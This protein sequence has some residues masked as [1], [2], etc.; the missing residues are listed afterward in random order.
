M[1]FGQSIKKSSERSNSRTVL[2][3]D[4]NFRE[5]LSGLYGEARNLIESTSEFICAVKLNMHLV[6]PLSFSDLESLN[7]IITER[8]L[9][10]IADLKVN[11]IDNTNL[12]ASRYLWKAGFSAV[13]VNPFVGYEGG[14]DLLIREAHSIEKGVISL[15]Y[16][17]HKG[18]DDGYGLKL[19]DG[20]TMFELMLERTKLWSADG[21]IVGATRT[22]MISKAR[23]DLGRDIKIFSP[24]HGAQGGEA[25]E[26]LKAGA[27]YLIYGRSIISARDPREAAKSI[28]HSVRAW[29][30]T[31]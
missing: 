24:G 11:D 31:R 16:M 28:H 30:K 27:D 20:R 21:V 15:A 19:A 17:S 1:T 14:L 23:E 12:I 5:D 26:S 7:Q 10:S 6:I 9:V 4:L 2:A 22:E 8:G 29:S 3:L 18:A 25:L 13:I